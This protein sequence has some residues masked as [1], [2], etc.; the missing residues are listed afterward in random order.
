MVWSLLF[1]LLIAGLITYQSPNK[2][3]LFKVY[4]INI[5]VLVI[6][7]CALWTYIF[8][9]LDTGG[10]SLGPGLMLLMFTGIHLIV[11]TIYIA[12]NYRIR[13]R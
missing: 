2:K 7:N 11:L 6:Y 10:A 12:W 13:P 1:V 9:Y 4:I 8:S 3:R 5:L